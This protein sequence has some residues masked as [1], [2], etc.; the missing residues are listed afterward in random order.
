MIRIEGKEQ[1]KILLIE[2]DPVDCESV[3]RALR[4]AFPDCHIRHSQCLAEALECAQESTFDVVL[5]DLSLPD[6]RGMESVISMVEAS[7]ESPIIVL[8]GHSP[9]E[10]SIKAISNGAQDYFVKGRISPELLQR[11]I[12]YAIRRHALS[13]KNEQLLKTLRDRDLMLQAKNKKLEKACRTA[14]QFVDNVSHEFRTPLTVIMEYASLLA[15][16]VAGPVNAEQ[17]KLLGVIDDRASDLNNMVDDMLDV[18]KLESGLLGASRSQQNV[19]DIIEYVLPAIQ[20]KADVRGVT[21]D[22]EIE[23]DLPEV[24]CDPDKA[25]RVIVNLAINAIKFSRSPGRVEIYAVR[26]GESDVSV[27]V[28]DNGV[29]IPADR[30]REIFQRFSQVT[31]ELRESTKGFGLGLNIAKELVDLNFGTMSVEST[32]GEGSV[33]S[34][35]IPINDPREIT[36]RF[37]KRLGENPDG[38]EEVTAVRISIDA[39]EPARVRTDVETFLVHLLRQNDLIFPLP[40]H[41]WIL[42]ISVPAIALADFRQRLEKQ[43]DLINRNRPRGPLPEFRILVDGTWPVGERDQELIGLVDHHLAAEESYVI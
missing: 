34:F 16:S 9:Q 3:T 31:T 42:L 21:L 14:Q 39:D 32:E 43:R 18:S 10:F 25:G 40:N 26:Y 1:I 7:P 17:S 2:D 36:Q 12:C 41:E 30:Q 6:S 15:D 5:V 11:S 24:F 4:K 22:V 29:G 27:G 8:T 37:L 20:R 28:V 13:R 19:A 23:D 38:P 35:T 33:F